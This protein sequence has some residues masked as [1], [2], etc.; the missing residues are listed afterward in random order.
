MSYL[1]SNQEDF[2]TIYKHKK[3]P[4]YVT[5][6][7]DFYRCISFTESF[8]GKTVS[9]LHSGNLRATSSFNRYS[10]LFPSEKVS[11]WADSV[12]TA[13]AEY[14]YHNKNNNI[15]TFW[16][17]DDASSTF[18]TI[19]NREPLIIVDGR[20]YNFSN[21]L[22]KFEKHI[23]LDGIERKALEEIQKLGPDC[24]A[25]ESYRRENGL[26]FLFFEKGFRKLAIREMRLRLGDY[27]GKNT[28]TITCA[29]SCDYTPYIESY[30]EYFMPLARIGYNSKYKLTDEYR[31]RE[32]YFDESLRRIQES[33]EK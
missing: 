1:F 14:K 20:N 32:K 28:N 33:Y 10:T 4:V 25:Y 3:Y 23:G 8:Y 5:N 16:A 29:G 2:S 24:L 19:S 26:N 15:I 21:I 31:M 7:F 11:Y 18:P 17:Y 22:K 30:G 13:R 6:A 27:R 9:E 12:K